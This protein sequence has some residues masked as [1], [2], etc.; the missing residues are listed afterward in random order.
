MQSD[1][2]LLIQISQCTVVAAGGLA[3]DPRRISDAVI[4]WLPYNRE[5]SITQVVITLPSREH[6]TTIAPSV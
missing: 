2:T 5:F 3:N 4:D 1:V 6:P